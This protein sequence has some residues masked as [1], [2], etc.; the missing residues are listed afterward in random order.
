MIADAAVKKNPV[1]FNEC[2][3]ETHNKYFLV[4]LVALRKDKKEEGLSKKR[5]IV[6]TQF[7]EAEAPVS[8]TDQ[9]PQNLAK[10]FTQADIP[11]LFEGLQSTVVDV[12]ITCL[13][14]FR[15][16]LSIE[17]NPPVQQCIDCGAVPHFVNFLQR[18]DNHTLQFEAAWALTNIA[19]TDRTQV[20]VESG[21][22]PLLVQL[23]QCPNPDIREQCAWCLG[24]IAGDGP[25]FRD[26]VLSLN[27]LPVLVAN[28]TQAANISL[29][30]NC[31]WA[32][33][34]FCR[35]KPQPSLEV[36]LPALPVLANIVIQN[37]DQDTMIGKLIVVISFIIHH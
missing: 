10:S 34:N 20:V 29:L 28:I 12:Q 13:R 1:S 30:R 31:T 26:I 23:L 9:L 3:E 27:A 22:L 5:N 8:T 2:I 17:Q 35:G 14:G 32:L 6:T 19:S 4:L 18:H 21:A 25:H 36:L 33:S 15:K 7:T 24:N 11:T 16:L 37:V